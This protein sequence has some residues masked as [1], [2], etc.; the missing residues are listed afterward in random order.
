M[1]TMT[2]T[3]SK[4]SNPLIRCGPLLRRVDRTSAVL[5]LEL[6][7]RLELE[8]EFRPYPITDPSFAFAARAWPVQIHGSYYGWVPLRFLLPDAWY[9]YEI[10]GRTPDGRIEHLWPDR[11]L[12]GISP[13][14]V[15]R[16][17]PYTSL[18]ELHLSFG[19]CRAGFPPGDPYGPREGNDALAA[20]ANELSRAYDRRT[21]NWPHLLILTGDQIYADT[22]S[23]AME[24]RFRQP[25][26]RDDER[27]VATT[28]G[29]FAAI[30][31]EAWTSD[32]VV[33][34]MLSSIPTLMIFDDHEVIDDWN[35]SEEWIEDRLGSLRWVRRLSDAVLAYW[36]Y[37]GAGN[38]DP[39]DWRGDERMRRLTPRFSVADADITRS[40]THLF[41]SYITKRR[42][43]TW[44]Y[45]L[46]AAGTTIAVADTRMSREFGDERRLMDQTSWSEFSSMAKS[47]RSR[48]II[49]VVPGPF[50]ISPPL[51]DI[52]GWLADKLDNDPSLGETLSS[53]LVGG[54]IGSLIGLGPL[55]LAL[56]AAWPWIKDKAVEALLN[57]WAISEYD[58]EL[59]SFFPSSFDDMLALLEDLAQGIGT[60]R[61]EQIHLIA[62]D[63]HHSY[64]MRGVLNRTSRMTVL[65]HFTMSPMRRLIAENDRE[66]YEDLMA[67]RPAIAHSLM[68][69]PSFV[70][71]QMRRL[72]WYPA[73]LDGS[74]AEVERTDDWAFFGTFVGALRVQMGQSRFSYDHAVLGSDGTLRLRP[75][76]GSVLYA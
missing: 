2:T 12:T 10:T 44:G 74:E 58:L 39:R 18:D 38:L 65:N 59:W 36:I 69:R 60:P 33:R 21:T 61:K 53:A 24:Q 34:W 32:K 28:F 72:H 43:A 67:G 55:G 9:T 17:L 30:Y 3:A 42:R 76:G 27:S 8:V 57:N 16:T 47:R 63:V 68:D 31:R 48:R 1:G 49:L 23:H 40:M 7:E 22:I 66:K 13:P 64:L 20:L 14:S 45:S 6:R 62:G 29:Q 41:E 54:A 75:L 25:P 70:E 52:Y 4:E 15:F 71:A 19:S 56:G 50:L 11:R 35:I 37:Q 73:H 46:E 26:L 51:H 5:W